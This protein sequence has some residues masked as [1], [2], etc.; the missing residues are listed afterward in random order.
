MLGKDGKDNKWLGQEISYN[1]NN[2]YKK[3]TTIT[4][5]SHFIREY[6]QLI[7]FVNLSFLCWV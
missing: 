1:S 6:V 4:S 2:N 7:I 3:N 5:V